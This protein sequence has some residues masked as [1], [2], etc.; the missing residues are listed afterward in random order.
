VLLILYPRDGEPWVLFTRR[1]DRVADH[2]GQICFP[3]GSKDPPDQ[4]LAATA[5]RETREELGVDPSTLQ[6]L[7]SLDPVYTVVTRYVIWPYVAYAP[8]RPEVVPDP[9]EVAEVIDVPIRRL[10]DPAARRVELWDTHGVPREV[11]FYDCGDNVIWGATARILKHFLDAYSDDWWRSVV[12]GN[13][14]FTAEEGGL[15][16]PV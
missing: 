3:G 8:M 16:T 5:L 14:R 1:T 12:G 10:L 15:P 4:S 13:V 2:K 7:R 11:Y 9:F 6:L